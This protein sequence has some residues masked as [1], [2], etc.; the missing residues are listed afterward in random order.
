MANILS[1][2][3]LCPFSKISEIENN[4]TSNLWAECP[5][6]SDSDPAFSSFYLNI[7]KIFDCS[8]PFEL[9][10]FFS[11]DSINLKFWFIKLTTP[12]F[13]T[14]T[15]D[16]NASKMETYSSDYFCLASTLPMNE[17]KDLASSW[18]FW[19]IPWLTIWKVI[20]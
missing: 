14:T 11:R 5:L 18:L 15:A 1:F 3:Y 13:L 6:M 16:D 7:L 12:F 9:L 17:I 2:R 20:T 10:D 8:M 19:M 4:C